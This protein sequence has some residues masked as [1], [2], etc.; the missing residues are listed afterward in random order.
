M[1]YLAAGSEAQLN[2]N[3]NIPE[4]PD[5]DMLARLSG[6]FVPNKGPRSISRLLTSIKPVPAK[7]TPKNL[8]ESA[9]QHQDMFM[10]PPW[11]EK[12]PK[13]A[14][15][16]RRNTRHIDL[17]AA[18]VPSSASDVLERGHVK[19]SVLTQ[20]Q[21]QGPRSDYIGVTWR[22]HPST[23]WVAQIR[24]LFCFC[25]LDPSC[26]LS[27]HESFPCLALPCLALSLPCLSLA[28]PCLELDT[29]EGLSYLA[30]LKQPKQ[31][32][33]SM[34]MQLATFIASLES[35]RGRQE[36]RKCSAISYRP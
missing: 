9:L 32:Q 22:S 35:F 23:P 3:D 21:G 12:L 19:P 7:R 26:L 29:K 8:N 4:A 5:A 18:M 16:E 20:G 6:V 30:V 2:S 1:S 33:P 24:C 11:A 27:S 14:P 10:A 36:K 17:Q 25:H 34:M 13:A 15:K 28:L 31:L